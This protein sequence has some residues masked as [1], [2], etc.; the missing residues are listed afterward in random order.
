[1]TFH[2][3]FYHLDLIN[4]FFF[5][6]ENTSKRILCGSKNSSEKNEFVFSKS[7]SQGRLVIVPFGYTFAHNHY[8]SSEPL[9]PS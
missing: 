1:M 5:Q 2:Q 6:I 9:S 3:Y 8:V 7:S 4:V